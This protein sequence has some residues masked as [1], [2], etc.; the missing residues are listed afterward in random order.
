MKRYYIE[1]DVHMDNDEHYPEP[2]EVAYQVGQGLPKEYFDA[3]D[4]WHIR[5]MR[6][7]ADGAALAIQVGEQRAEIA[8]LE[9]ELSKA[10]AQAERLNARNDELIAAKVQVHTEYTS[11]GI[12]E[13]EVE[14]LVDV[15]EGEV[16]G[17]QYETIDDISQAVD[18]LS[19]GI[20]DIIRD[21]LPVMDERDLGW[22]D[23]DQ[24]SVLEAYAE[25]L[26]ASANGLIDKLD[27]VRTGR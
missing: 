3:G 7:S 22:G 17:L 9:N 4:S 12:T 26:Q 14:T 8:G 21:N 6:V 5:G 19:G 13:D 2:H 18:R 10:L 27:A 16:S 24:L 1:V 23:D 20:G 25:T 11:V 15:L